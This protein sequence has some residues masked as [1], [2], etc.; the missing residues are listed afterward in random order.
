MTVSE[1]KMLE[2]MENTLERLKI[3]I[4]ELKKAD[5]NGFDRLETDDYLTEA[6]N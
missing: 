1:R 2:D 5:N 6:Y 4:K 3:E